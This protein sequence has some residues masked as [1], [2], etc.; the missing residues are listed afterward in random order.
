MRLILRKKI[1]LKIDR[2]SKGA[3]GE[4][5]FI[6]SSF[7]FPMETYTGERLVRD[8]RGLDK[9]LHFFTIGLT[10]QFDDGD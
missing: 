4:F 6:Y 3:D 2:G 10:T 8:I 9:N 1:T 7:L 5:L